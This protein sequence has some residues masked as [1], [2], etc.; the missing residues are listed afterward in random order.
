MQDTVEFGRVLPS[1]D[2][3]RGVAVAPGQ[4]LLVVEPGAKLKKADRPRV[5]IGGQ[6]RGVIPIAVAL[7]P[8]RHELVLVRGASTSFRYLV[9]RAGE[10]R[11]VTID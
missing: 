9:I 10:T 8:G 1:I 7:H 5:K 2:T 6:D 4:G 3:A 11:I